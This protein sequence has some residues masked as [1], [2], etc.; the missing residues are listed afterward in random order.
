[1]RFSRVFVAAA[2]SALFTVAATSKP[3]HKQ[4]PQQWKPMMNTEH[5]KAYAAEKDCTGIEYE[6]TKLFAEVDNVGASAQID[7]FTS[8]AG[9]DP[10][11]ISRAVATG[12][13]MA[14]IYNGL[15]QIALAKG[16]PAQ[17]R[18]WYLKTIEGFTGAAY[19]AQRERAKI[20]L[21]DVRAYK[22]PTPAAP[23]E[24]AK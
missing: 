12:Q 4:E 9:R 23:A 7:L 8:R 21:D 17:A 2:S 13:T 1:M 14:I 10:D 20:G 19:A 16:C 5:L 22:P 3:I 11:Y 15:G 18:E 24:A 6:H